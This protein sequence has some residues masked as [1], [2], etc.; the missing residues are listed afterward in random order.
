MKFFQNGIAGVTT[1]L[2]DEYGRLSGKYSGLQAHHLN[3]N[4]AFSSVV[5][6]NR[7]ISIVLYG[8]ICEQKDSAH[9]RVHQAIEAF[10][11]LYRE[12]G[13]RFEQDIKIS[14]YLDAVQ[15]ALKDA[16]FSP[17]EAKG[18]RSLAAAQLTGLIFVPVLPRPINC[19]SA[20]KEEG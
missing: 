6:R 18:L 10:W 9:S 17:S 4:A 15:G 19:F 1:D 14:D 13:P 11:D 7:G 2:V 16:G 3:Q 8:N 5:P 12:G 20:D